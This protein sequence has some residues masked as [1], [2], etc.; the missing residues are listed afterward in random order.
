PH[1]RGRPARSG[2]RGHR[3]PDRRGGAGRITPVTR[4]DSP[5]RPGPG[6]V[7]TPPERPAERG[8]PGLVRAGGGGAG[9]RARGVGS[10]THARRGGRPDLTAPFPAPALPA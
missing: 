9:G 1:G 5:R 10:A 8:R 6:D 2:G 3:E 4:R 7:R